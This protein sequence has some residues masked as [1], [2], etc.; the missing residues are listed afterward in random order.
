MSLGSWRTFERIPR[1]QGVAVMRAAQDAGI[2]FLDD[3]RYDDE[4]G[5]API[6]TGYSEVVFGEV[7]RAAGWERD[8]VTVANKLWWEHWPEQSAAEELDASL[9]RMGLEHVDLIYAM[10]P[11]D[12]LE[13]ADVVEQVSELLDSGRARRW[14]TGM[15]TGAQLHAALDACESSGVA[16]PV[17][18]QM[19]HSLVD[20]AQSMDPSIVAALDRGDI[21]LVAAYALAG[22]T[23]TGKYLRG[24]A[25]RAADDDGATAVSGRARA[26][27]VLSL[28]EAW[29]VP[30]SHV[31]FA[32]SL[33][34]PNLSSVVFGATSPEQLA[35]NVAAHTTFLALTPAER[36]ALTELATTA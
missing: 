2:D 31:A 34:H 21:G 4:S 13:V 23:L 29:G 5:T 19:A 1:E 18:A 17:A 36:A 25:G 20:H 24:E 32:Y 33:S 9:E 11:P 35:E 26:A 27:S 6:P 28:A 22:G 30:A 16:G 8:E 7:F 12:G 3:A 10:P 14:G 15:W